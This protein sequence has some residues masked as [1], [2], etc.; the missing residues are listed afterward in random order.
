MKQLSDLFDFAINIIV[1]RSVFVVF[2][3]YLVEAVLSVDYFDECF[4]I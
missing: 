4:I 2:H 1:F 3:I